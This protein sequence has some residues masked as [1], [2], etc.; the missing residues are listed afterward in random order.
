M[1]KFLGLKIYKFIN[2]KYIKYKIKFIGIHFYEIRYFIKT[3]TW[4][5][6]MKK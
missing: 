1:L 4:Y 5:M 3:Q 2:I 6:Y